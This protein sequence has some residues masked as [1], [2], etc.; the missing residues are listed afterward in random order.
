VQYM[1]FAF[2]GSGSSG[3]AIGL[4]RIDDFDRGGGCYNGCGCFPPGYR[5]PHIVLKRFLITLCYCF[6]LISTQGLCS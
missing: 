5:L 2:P 1:L 3:R 4:L 6:L